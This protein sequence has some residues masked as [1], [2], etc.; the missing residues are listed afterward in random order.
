VI[1]FRRGGKRGMACSYFVSI[2]CSIFARLVLLEFVMLIWH[3]PLRFD[4][5]VF[6]CFLSLMYAIN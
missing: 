4:S 3:R 1:F 6:L 5:V 2:F